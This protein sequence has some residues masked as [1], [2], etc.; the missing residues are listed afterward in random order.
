MTE[1]IIFNHYIGSALWATNLDNGEPMDLKYDVED[2]HPDT[3]DKLKT[4]MNQFIEK[5][6]YLIDDEDRNTGLDYFVH[7]FWLTR[8]GHGAGFWDGDYV[9]GDALTDACKEY[10]EIYLYVGDDGLIYI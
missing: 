4:E 7:N 8:N 1:E 3:R 2:L 6:A 10:G 9:N 5:Y